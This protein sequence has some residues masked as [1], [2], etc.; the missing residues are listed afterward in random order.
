MRYFAFS[1]LFF[2]TYTLVADETIVPHTFQADRR[3]VA[4]EVNENFES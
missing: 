3:A 4:S 1:S 2:F